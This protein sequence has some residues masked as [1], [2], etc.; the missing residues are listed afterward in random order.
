[1]KR[2]VFA[3]VF[4]LAVFTLGAKGSALTYTDDMTTLYPDQI[5]RL[6]GFKQHQFSG[7][8]RPDYTTV[9]PELKAPAPA[10]A[11]YRVRSATSV[12][13]YLY[14]PGGTFAE[15]DG[16]LGRYRLGIYSEVLAFDPSRPPAQAMLCPDSGEVYTEE[17]GLK[18]LTMDESENQY[19]FE[20]YD[21]HAPAG[22]AMGYG[23]NIYYSVDGE[24]FTRADAGLSY[25]Y[26]D[27]D[28]SVFYEAYTA[29]V[30]EAA[31]YIR[32]SVNEMS[33]LRYDGEP[34][35]RPY[36]ANNAMGVSGLALA[37]VTI[38][39]PSLVPGVYDEEV[40]ANLPS[41]GYER[42]RIIVIRDSSSRASSRASSSGSASS[43]HPQ[44]Q[45]ARR[46]PR[47]SSRG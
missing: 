22:K 45:E 36:D 46:L 2:A 41:D 38:Y 30:P 47:Q 16:N 20:S 13:A 3:A 21:S 8:P 24:S 32:V 5:R 44:H 1:M 9:T 26:Y 11:E 37:A 35:A 40:P 15:F 17:G 18:W 19:I 14:S 27:S 10:Y 31:Q 23:V 42:E 7:A 12:T 43:S 6:S 34:Q 29:G 28:N 33:F 39:G 25:F 4:L